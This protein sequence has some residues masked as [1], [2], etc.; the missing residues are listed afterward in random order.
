MQEHL[1]SLA[2]AQTE[3][4]PSGSID[5]FEGLRQ[6]LVVGF[7]SNIARRQPDGRFR[8]LAT[9]QDIY[10]HP[11][12]ALLSQRP[13]CVVFNELVHTTKMYAQCVSVVDAAWL[14]AQLVMGTAVGA[15]QAAAH[16]KA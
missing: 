5:N 15:A 12:S 13:K 10:L 9:G 7:A 1:Q 8:V 4:A 3:A 6:A 2:P 11:S 14:P 16:Y